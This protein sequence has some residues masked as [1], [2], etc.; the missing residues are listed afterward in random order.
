[1]QK[2]AIVGAG[3]VGES[4]AL[5]I[6]QHDLCKELMLIDIREGVP[7]GVAL[8]IQE[9]APLLGFD[10]QIRGSH[11]A[12]AVAGAQLVVITAGL[13]RKPGMSR[14]D[15]LESNVKIIDGIV[16]SIAQHAPEAI[17]LLVSN[18]VDTLTWEAFVR[19]GFP[20][21]R[22][23]GQAGVLDST[24]MASFIAMETGLSVKDI[25]AMVLGG[26]GDSMVPM[27][28]FT[29]LSGIPVE[30]F[31]DSSAIESIV[32]RTRNGGA[33]ILSLR[34]NSSAY[35]APAA[36]ITTMVD[37]IVRGRRRVLP[38]V[39]I[40]DGEYGYGGL[41]MGVPCV[42]G[43]GGVERIVELP[44]NEEEKRMFDATVAAIQRDIAS[45]QSSH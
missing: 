37:A 12:S 11:D 3:R 33:E 28:R 10:T 36:A 34:Q 5:F 20:R 39:A 23:L 31:L 27:T 41:A 26:H 38:S 9:T 13:P 35:D 42:L 8:D 19:S 24:R 44:L 2:I 6:A 30:H 29:T 40:L 43:Q 7:Q 25:D 14:S 45:L 18:P 16:D 1:M 22:V 21:H 4:T 32:E 15:V 17:L